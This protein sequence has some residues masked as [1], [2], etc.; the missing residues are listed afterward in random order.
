[1]HSLFFSSDVKM[2]KILKTANSIS[3]VNKQIDPVNFQFCD[4]LKSLFKIY[5]KPLKNTPL[6]LTLALHTPQLD[7][8]Q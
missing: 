3:A 1:M 8:L 4:H 6:A 2:I 5:M 7:W